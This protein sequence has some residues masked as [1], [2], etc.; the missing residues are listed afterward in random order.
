MLEISPR[1]KLLLAI[2]AAM[3]ALQLLNAFSGYS[4]N[5]WGLAPRRLSGLTGIASSPFLHEGFRHLLSN[6]PPLL[7]LG[8]L[9]ST[10]GLRRFLM[11]STIIIVGGGLLVWLFARPGL[12]VGASGWVFGLWAFLLAQAWHHR[13]LW[14]LAKGALVLF[15]YGGLVFGLLPNGF[16]SFESHLAGT[17]CGI[18]AAALLN[19]PQTE[20]QPAR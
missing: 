11:A 2:A 19:R 4:L 17:L 3:I 1:T 18:L 12:H 8:W 6:L 10:D 15:L 13:S 20:T 16:V 5:A 9:V 7:V 14:N